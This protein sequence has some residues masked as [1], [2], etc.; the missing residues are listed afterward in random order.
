MIKEQ[1]K[2]SPEGFKGYLGI[3]TSM[4]NQS[5]D[6]P[7]RAFFDYANQVAIYLANLSLRQTRLLGLFVVSD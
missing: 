7:S 2:I 6:S 5:K 4:G 3:K 1:E